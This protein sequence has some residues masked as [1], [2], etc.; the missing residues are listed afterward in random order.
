MESNR[1]SV[2]PFSKILKRILFLSC[3]T[4][5]KHYLSLS[6]V[7]MICRIVFFLQNKLDHFILIYGTFVFVMQIIF[8]LNKRLKKFL[9]TKCILNIIVVLSLSSHLLIY[10]KEKTENLEHTIINSMEIAV[11]LVCASKIIKP[12]Y[13][14]IPLAIFI[15]LTILLKRELQTLSCESNDN[16][17]MIVFLFFMEN[18]MLVLPYSKKKS[19]LSNIPNKITIETTTKRKVSFSAREYS[20]TE[21]YHD[22]LSRGISL[23]TSLLNNLRDGLIVIDSSFKIKHF[24]NVIVSYFKTES[25][26]ELKN[27][28]LNLVE[29]EKY[30]K[31]SRFP[32]FPAENFEIIIDDFKKRMKEFSSQKIKIDKTTSQSFECLSSIPLIKRFVSLKSMNQSIKTR[33]FLTPSVKS[34]RG[35]HFSTLG[36]FDAGVNFKIMD[37]S[38]N[39]NMSELL[40]LGQFI[41]VRKARNYLKNL[42]LRKRMTSNI[43]GKRSNE[44]DEKNI[45]NPL[46][47]KMIARSSKANESNLLF[48]LEFELRNDNSDEAVITVRDL[49]SDIFLMRMIEYEVLERKFISTLCH[50]LKTPLNSITNMLIMMEETKVFDTGQSINEYINS[51][52]VNSKFLISSI[53][54][55]LDYFDL[56]SKGLDLNYQRFNLRNL[57]QETY[58]TFQSLMK[59][60]GVEFLF[61]YD[62]TVSDEIINDERRIRQILFNLLS[63]FFFSFLKIFFFKDNAVRHT[64]AKGVIILHLK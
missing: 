53:D 17:I 41:R 47:F 51:A 16:N 45:K 15:Y 7:I 25:L 20:E 4:K 9:S 14:Y 31:F 24:N 29:D 48:M 56:K 6:S 44:N 60:K 57:L 46:N 12:R 37:Y 30:L 61:E 34:K 54:D 64:N 55:F 49:R 39:N 42:F 58:I 33:T 40:K 21:N 23:E 8:I 27:A 3:K 11:L 18:I 19:D 26:E 28:V 63:K 35:S 43:Y 22:K 52:L 36:V 32:F 2:N 5:E 13:L 59:N 50:E 38:L 10:L 1:N 62:E